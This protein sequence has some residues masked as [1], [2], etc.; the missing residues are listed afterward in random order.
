MILVRILYH[1]KCALL[2]MNYELPRLRFGIGIC[3][4]CRLPIMV[5]L[6]M[7]CCE[8]LLSILLHCNFALLNYELSIMVWLGVRCGQIIHLPLQVPQKCLHLKN[9]NLFQCLSF[10]IHVQTSLRS[11]SFFLYSKRAFSLS[12]S[13][14]IS[15]H[16]TESLKWSSDHTYYL[17]FQG[18]SKLQLCS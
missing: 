17:G 6:R 9:M 7:R 2:I 10:K 8:I 16:Y 1:C 18:L 13:V 15:G 4:L 12:G 14:A 3:K 11:A 5:W